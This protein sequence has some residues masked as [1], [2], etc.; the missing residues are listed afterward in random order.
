MSLSDNDAALVIF[1][2]FKGQCISNILCLLK[3]NHIRF[4][5]VPFNCTNRFQPLDVRLNTALKEDLQRQI[6]DWYSTQMGKQLQGS[7]SWPTS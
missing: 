5:V 4:V 2:Q 6:Q 1:D 7:Y 3:N